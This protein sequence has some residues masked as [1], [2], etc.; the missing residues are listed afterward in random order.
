ML[1]DI[2][3]AMNASSRPMGLCVF[4]DHVPIMPTVYGLLGEPDGTTDYLY[5]ANNAASLARPLQTQ[6]RDLQAYELA[7]GFLD[8]LG[9]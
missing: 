1:N 8:G 7:R 4:G 9:L 3:T 2:S 6:A 5:W